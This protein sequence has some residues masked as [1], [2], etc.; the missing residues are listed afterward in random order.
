MSPPAGFSSSQIIFED[1]FADLSKWNTYMA[2]NASGGWP[3][4]SN[5]AGGSGVGDQ[6]DL[7]YDLPGGVSTGPGGLT[8]T[9][10][11][12]PVQGIANGSGFTF[13]WRS[14]AVTTYGKFA[15][16]GGY[17]QIRAKMPAGDGMWPGLWLLPGPGSNSGD[18]FELDMYEGGYT[19]NGVSANDND[20]W[21][22]HTP[23]GTLGGTTN[24]GVDLTAGYHI[25]GVNW[26][27]G[28]SITWYLD[29]KEFAQLTS[30]QAQIPDEPMELIMNLQVAN[31][32]TAGW[33]TLVDSSTPQSVQMNV[34]E[35]QVYS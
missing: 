31:G 18:N 35:V 5:G 14:G 30:A 19:G 10:T 16:T 13:P 17:V 3:W 26:V 23:S 11:Q 12:D 9:A 24:V 28:K 22:L 7:D 8:I 25:Y 1:T 32:A 27:P 33:H 6:Y 20:A 21:H 4:N 2:S 34:A 15:F 29:G